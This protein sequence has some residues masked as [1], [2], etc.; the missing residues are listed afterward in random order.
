VSTAPPRR[1]L[2]P[3]AIIGIVAGGVVVLGV[4]AAVAV[5]VVLLVVGR[6]AGSPGP[7]GSAESTPG[8]TVEAYLRAVADSDAE[9]ALALLTSPPDD[10]TLLT[11][12][13]LEASNAAAPITGIAA[14]EPAA[15][16]YYPDVTAT[17]AM[18][19]EPVTATFSLTA[20]ADGRW[21]ILGG[22]AGLSLGI[23]FG[24]LD[25]TL[26][27]VPVERDD[28]E[29]FP[30]TYALATTTPEFTI[31]DGDA[32]RVV[33]PYSF[34]LDE[35]RPALS[36][37]GLVV[38]GDAIRASV[39]PCLASRSLAAGCGLDL[40]PELDD[41]S[42]PVDGTVTR[43]L[44]AEGQ[45]RLA[46]PQP[47]ELFRDPLLVRAEPIGPVETRARFADGVDGS[48]LFAPSLGSPL[49]DFTGPEPVVRWD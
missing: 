46:A 3:A 1:G 22:T 19:G 20:D 15:D 14:E 39:A 5:V 6:G 21:S 26:N 18:G 47:Q 24:G 4:L 25:L 29:V 40:P 32:I 16:E 41:G 38:F 44:S 17:Y 7:G 9:A 23:P 48:I 31:V 27:G 37:Q 49:V 43:A 42:R 11:D 35:V 12:E 34:P 33:D 2:P 8:E 30:G 28:V 45:A 10:R 36:E 13:V